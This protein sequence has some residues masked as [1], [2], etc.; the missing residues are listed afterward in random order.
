MRRKNKKNIFFSN[1]FYY[2]KFAR[3]A[4]QLSSKEFVKAESF[5]ER[6][7]VMRTFAAECFDL[8]QKFRK[9]DD[10]RLALQYTKLAAKM[11]GLSL[12][13]KKLSDLDEIK[14]TLSDLKAAE[15]MEQ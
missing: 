13:P 4:R 10:E 3:I 7:A 2:K 8:A 5:A 1:G 9:E 14:R 15:K 11:L 12:R 6:D